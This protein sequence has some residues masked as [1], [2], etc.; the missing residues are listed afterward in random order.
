MPIIVR[1]NGGL[2]NQMFQYAA[3]KRLAEKRATELK[4][5]LSLFDRQPG[6]SYELNRFAVNEKFSTKREVRSLKYGM[7]SFLTRLSGSRRKK[8]RRLSSTYILE[9]GFQFDP[10]ILDLPDNVL[11]EGYWQ[12]EK[13]F[14][15]IAE[16]IRKIFS[17]RWIST[18]TQEV[19]ARIRNCDSV[20]VHIRRGDYVLNEKTSQFH[21]ICTVAYYEE[22]VRKVSETVAPLH[23]FIFSDDITWC[24]ANLVFPYE[25]TFV[26]RGDTDDPVGDLYL[27]SLCLHN[28]IANSSFSWWAAWLNR[29]PGKMVFAPARWFNDLSINIEDLIPPSWQKIPL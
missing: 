28:I 11:L 22:C 16:L 12:S 23:L 17:P 14:S 29:N 15:D 1:L 18:F 3:G 9:K 26:D 4:M 2:G 21:G 19:S 27:M 5:D 7:G 6:C 13:Y 24:R 25:T 20:G 8:A 10:D